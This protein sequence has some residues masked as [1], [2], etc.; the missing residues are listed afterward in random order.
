[1]QIVLYPDDKLRVQTKSVETVT[2]ELIAT[3][4]EMYE[5]MKASNGIGLSAPQVGLD[6]SL[7]VLEDNGSPM[8]LFNPVILNRSK[9][10]E[11]T[12]EGC[13]SFPDVWR[14]IKRSKEVTVKYRGT[15]GKMQYA[16]LKGL[17]ARCLI[18]EVDHLNGKLFIDLEEREEKA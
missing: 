13:L 2:P 11:Y 16:V 15:N 17:Q 8:I 4:I 18:H 7:I 10:T 6:I 9:D 3:A 14:I 5:L 1:M 12:K